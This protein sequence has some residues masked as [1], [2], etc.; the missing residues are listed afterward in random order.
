MECHQIIG[1]WVG[2]KLQNSR[3]DHL[4]YPSILLD[5][6]ISLN[7]APSIRDPVLERVEHHA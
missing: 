7:V 3:Q 1:W 5:Q 4:Q 2:T 6:R